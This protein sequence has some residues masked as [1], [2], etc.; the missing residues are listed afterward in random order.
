MGDRAAN[1]GPSWLHERSPSNIAYETL[2]QR[3]DLGAT[4]CHLGTIMGLSWGYLGGAWA[5]LNSEENIKLR[6]PVFVILYNA[7]DR[8]L[9][10]RLGLGRPKRRL[11]GKLYNKM[12]GS[13]CESRLNGDQRKPTEAGLRRWVGEGGGTTVLAPQFDDP[14]KGGGSGDSM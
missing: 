2:F 1:V 10:S 11:H 4:L 14:P 9:S 13:G 6:R 7:W 12:M 5:I 8:K 3:G